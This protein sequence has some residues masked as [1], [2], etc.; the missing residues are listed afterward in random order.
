MPVDYN[1][2]PE[3]WKTEIRPHIM[4][5]SQ[6]RCELCNAKNYENHPM[7]GSKVV[8]TIHHIDCDIKNNNDL[9]LIALCQRCH[10]RLDQEKHA[11]TRAKNKLIKSGQISLL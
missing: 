7:T 10:L 1:K 8:L 6:D 4:R 5:R 11:R 9:N 2:Y 3:N